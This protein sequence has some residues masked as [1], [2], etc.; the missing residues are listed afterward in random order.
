MHT[1]A[2][3]KKFPFCF[4]GTPVQRFAMDKKKVIQQ[5]SPWARAQGRSHQFWSDQVENNRLENFLGYEY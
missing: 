5:P 4:W 3:N 1:V 2:A